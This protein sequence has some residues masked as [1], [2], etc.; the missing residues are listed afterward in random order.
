MF[1]PRK[2]GAD[3]SRELVCTTSRKDT[4]S[5]KLAEN[6]KHYFLIV[7]CFFSWRYSPLWLYFHSPVAVFS[8]LVFEVSRSHTQR[9]AT[10]G[11]TPLYE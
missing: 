7:R 10:V 6:S 5:L 1:Y 2:R 8:L 4:Y 9:R 3:W 11:R